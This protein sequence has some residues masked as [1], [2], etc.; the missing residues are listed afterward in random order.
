M[1]DYCPSQDWDRYC[2][3]NDWPDHICCFCYAEL[4]EKDP[5]I[6]NPLGFF[7]NGPL[8]SW[9]QNGFCSATCMEG[10]CEDNGWSKHNDVPR[11]V[12]QWFARKEGKTIRS[13]TD[14]F[15]HY[16]CT[17]KAGEPVPNGFRASGG[18]DADAEPGN[19]PCTQGEADAM[20]L[21]SLRRTF[22]KYTAA[23]LPVDFETN[24]FDPRGAFTVYPYCEGSDGLDCNGGYRVR[25]PCS[26]AELDAAEKE[27]EDESEAEWLRTHGCEKCW[28]GQTVCDEWGNEAGPEDYGMRPV[29]P[30]CKSCDGGGVVI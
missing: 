13:A 26:V 25:L 6:P 2:Q 30:K 11:T 5:G 9:W 24:E 23:G 7:G 29:D 18:W 1:I 22:F 8:D 15:D 3:M 12:V 20:S 19:R 28:G 16:G 4:P 27:A 14:L 17:V 21:R 10:Y